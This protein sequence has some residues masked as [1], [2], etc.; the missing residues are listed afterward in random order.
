MILKVCSLD[1]Q[2]L[3]HL[4]CRFSAPLPHTLPAPPP[5]MS[6]IRNPKDGTQHLCCNKPSRRRRSICSLRTR[7]LGNFKHTRTVTQ[8]FLSSPGLE[9]NLG[10]YKSPGHSPGTWIFLSFSNGAK[11]HSGLGSADLLLLSVCRGISPTASPEIIRLFPDTCSAIILLGVG[12]T[13]QTAGL[14]AQLP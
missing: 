2:G 1:Q 11:S 3:R 12:S 14:P 8:R 10:G 7:A 9:E 6:C 4:K 5:Q 13:L